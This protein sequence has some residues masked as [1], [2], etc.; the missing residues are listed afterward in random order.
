ML[1]LSSGSLCEPTRSKR[2]V[3]FPVSSSRRFIRL[4]VFAR[5]QSRSQSCF[6]QTK[7]GVT[8]WLKKWP[9]ESLLQVIQVELSLQLQLQLQLRLEPK[10]ELVE[11]LLQSLIGCKAIHLITHFNHFQTRLFSPHSVWFS[12]A[13]PR[14]SFEWGSKRGQIDIWRKTWLAHNS[15]SCRQ[16]IFA[17]NKKLI[18]REKVCVER[19][20]NRIVSVCCKTLKVLKVALSYMDD[21][22]IPFVFSSQTIELWYSLNLAKLA[23]KLARKKASFTLVASISQDSFGDNFE[24]LVFRE[25]KNRHSHD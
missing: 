15:S 8:I 13:K 22:N 6:G 3:Y 7:Q 18:W 1:V 14:W 20:E 11:T 19:R 16:H 10:P 2:A 24:L 5:S 25:S 23:L 4:G 9:K 17:R 12:L 21:N